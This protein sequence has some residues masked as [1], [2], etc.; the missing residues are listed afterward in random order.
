MPTTFLDVPELTDRLPQTEI[1]KEVS[2]KENR[3]YVLSAKYKELNKD[4]DKRTVLDLSIKTVFQRIL[5]TIS[6]I[7][8]DLIDLDEYTLRKV[9]RVFIEGDRMVYFGIFVV[10]VSVLLF[11]ISMSGWKIDL[12]KILKSYNR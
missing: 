10:M 6:S 12:N 8:E 3:L 2:K 5:Y 4:T 1:K 11:M 9:V 7:V